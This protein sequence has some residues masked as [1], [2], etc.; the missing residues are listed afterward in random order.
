MK[1]IFYKKIIRQIMTY[2]EHD[3]SQSGKNIFRKMSVVEIK[4]KMLRYRC[5]KTR[6]GIIKMTVFNR[7]T[8]RT[9]LRWFRYVQ[10]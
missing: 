7:K 10:R 5:G 8:K 2:M 3:V 6:K 1:E 9:R 4:I